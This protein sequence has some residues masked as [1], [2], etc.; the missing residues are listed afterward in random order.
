MRPNVAAACVLFAGLSGQA[1]AQVV[2]PPPAPKPKEEYTPPPPPAPRPA[3][4]PREVE[5]AFD[6]STVEFDPIY[7]RDDEG[8]IVGPEGNVEVAAVLNNPLVAEDVRPII[9]ELLKERDA[10]AEEIVIREPRAA[11]EYAGGV[12]DRMDFAERA[13]IEA[14]STV[15]QALQLGDG[16][17]VDLANQGLLSEQ[18]RIMSVHIW[19]D[20]NKAVTAE[21]AATFPDSEEPNALLNAQSRYL[22]NTSMQ[23]IGLAFDRVARRALARLDSPEAEA[24]LAI[25]GDGFRAE[26]GSVLGRLSDERLAEV[27][28]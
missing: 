1:A 21:L 27:M 18:G 25:E 3:A 8:T 5:P 24:A 16:V 14:V 17:I 19:Q 11:I 2:T 12:V 20:Y 10:Q 26:A 4:Q 23:E 7:T 28:Q 13:T 22:M 9:E 6:P 15:A